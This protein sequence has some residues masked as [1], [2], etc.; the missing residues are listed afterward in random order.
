MVSSQQLFNLVHFESLISLKQEKFYAINDAQ[1]IYFPSKANVL[2]LTLDDCYMSKFVS[3]INGYRSKDVSITQ[4]IF[5]W[6]FL[7]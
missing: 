7:E 6:F 4:I 5:D 2:E 3:W 1:I